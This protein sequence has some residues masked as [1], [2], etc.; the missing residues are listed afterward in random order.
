MHLFKINLKELIF[1]IIFSVPIGAFL[2][3][4]N[5]NK[6]TIENSF[7]R[8][9][10][11]VHNLCNNIPE[12]F[13]AEILS[14]SDIYFL[15]NNHNTG[16][17]NVAIEASR[18]NYLYNIKLKGTKEQLGVGGQKITQIRNDLNKLESDSFK[19]LLGEI[20]LHCGATSY[21]L[22][23]YIPIPIEIGK[24]NIKDSYKF[25]YLLFIS[26]CPLIILYFLIISIKYFYRNKL[27]Y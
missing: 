17:I 22:Y 10:G 7:P 14:D 5:A 1:V 6:I 3:M 18:S 21:K 2:Y 9:Y 26:I 4:H 20:E 23:K 16:E 12:K 27:K 24:N 13:R 25:S 19:N 11:Y 8:G 15:I